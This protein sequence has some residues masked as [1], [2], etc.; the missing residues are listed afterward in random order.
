MRIEDTGGNVTYTI[1]DCDCGLTGGCN[2]CQPLHI[3]NSNITYSFP[4][5]AVSGDCQLNQGT[6]S[7]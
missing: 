1:D 3:P 5:R 2:K 6:L 7:T 4:V